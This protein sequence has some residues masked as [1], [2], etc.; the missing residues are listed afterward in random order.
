MKKERKPLINDT[1]D[2]F[3]ALFLGIFLLWFIAILLLPIFF[4]NGGNDGWTENID[5]LREIFAEEEDL[6]YPD[7]EALG[8]KDVGAY[9][10]YKKGNPALPYT[11]SGTFET[12]DGEVTLRV[13]AQ[14]P[15][16]GG[17]VL[18]PNETIGGVMARVV[19]KEPKEQTEVVPSEEKDE[20]AYKWL[21][22]TFFIDGYR[23][24][25][26]GQTQNG[27][28]TEALRQQTLAVAQNIIG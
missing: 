4:R 11:A 20:T 23:Y 26:T 1:F 21:E 16:V 22:V 18:L 25:V 14:K 10:E 13:K 2:W 7:L 9:Y 15:P 19:E 6:R 24:T 5:E 3:A 12:A 17:A 28:I 8:A 27:E